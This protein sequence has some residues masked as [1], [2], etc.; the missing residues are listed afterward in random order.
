M[1]APVLAVLCIALGYGATAVFGT[2]MVPPPPEILGRLLALVLGGEIAAEG[3]RTLGRGLAGV[4]AANLV[5]IVLGL[6][7]GAWAPAARVFRPLLAALNACPPVVWIA[8]AMVWI[9]S[10]GGTPVFAVAA[11]TLPPLFLAVL[12]GVHAVDPRLAAMSRLYGVPTTTQLRR[13]VAPTA[14]PFWRAAFAHTAAAAWKVA[15][16]AE[17]LGSSDGIGASIYWAYRRLEMADLYAWA[18]TIMLLGVAIDAGL[19]RAGGR[20]A[21]R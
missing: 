3:L 19:A 14:L 7:A 9:G 17:F 1:I 18:L 2:A 10:G 12:E 21:A 16:V 4:A 13:L 6:A 5:G 8:L 15:A 11:A 20:G